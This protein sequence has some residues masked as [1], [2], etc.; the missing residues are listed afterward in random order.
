M[1]EH[2]AVVVLAAGS[3]TRMKSATAKV[4]HPLAGLSLIE[5]VLATARALQPGRLITVLK[6]QQDEIEKA[7]TGLADDIEFVTQS[8]IP[9]NRLSCRIGNGCP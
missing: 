6:H 3:G 9:G 2:L 8:D 7:L 4:L 1:N 5:H